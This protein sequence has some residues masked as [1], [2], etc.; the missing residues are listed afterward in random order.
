ML[1][2]RREKHS[3][4]E[5]IYDLVKVGFQTAEVSNGLEHDYVGKLRASDKYIPELALVAEE[6]GK[7]IGH[8]MLTKTYVSCNT[9]RFEALLLAPLCVAKEH[10]NLGIGSKLIMESFRLAKTLGYKAVFVVGNPLFYSRFGFRSSVLFG[11]KHIPMI[12]DQF[13]MVIELSTGALADVVG[14]VAFT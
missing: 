10:R 8:I 9:S 11:I 4:F 5:N 13:V 1:K 14:T 7:I 3:D 12:P 2:I 6:I